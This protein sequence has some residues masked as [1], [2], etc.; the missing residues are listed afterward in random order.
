M[1]NILLSIK[2]ILLG[3]AFILCA[4]A[5]TPIAP[6]LALAILIVGMFF[7][8]YGFFQAPANDKKQK[9]TR[10]QMNAKRASRFDFYR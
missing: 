1:E 8:I 2:L 5:L 6:T 4:I 9:T 7:S 10:I 3:I